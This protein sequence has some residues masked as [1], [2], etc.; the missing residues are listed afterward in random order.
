M[1]FFLREAIRNRLAQE[2]R[3]ASLLPQGT[4]TP[5]SHGI[6]STRLHVS[7]LLGRWA[8]ACASF[9]GAARSNG[10]EHAS[11]NAAFHSNRLE[12]ALPESG[13]GFG[14]RETCREAARN[15]PM[16]V[17]PA[18]GS[19]LLRACRN[20]AAARMRSCSPLGRFAK[21][22][23]A[24]RSDAVVVFR[25]RR[26]HRSSRLPPAAVRHVDGAI[27]R[28]SFGQFQTLLLNRSLCPVAYAASRRLQP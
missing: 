10:F 1:T 11:G 19:F 21:A 28:G 14:S 22:E 20:A 24:A 9:E 7:S 12:S 18:R 23:A 4:P 6:S 15:R 26:R 17:G 16:T 27:R 5:R 2:S 3:V 25:L 13:C 8:V